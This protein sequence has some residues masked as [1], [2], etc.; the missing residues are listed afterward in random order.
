MPYDF[1]D[2]LDKLPPKVDIEPFHPS[3]LEY[4]VT[5]LSVAAIS[6][7]PHPEATFTFE[8]LLCEARTLGDLDERDV[9]L[10]L[11]GVRFLRRAV[12]RGEERW[13]LV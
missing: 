6:L 4:I 12:A 3:D 9:R 13:L 2:A 7:T 1:D 11:P 10:V 8:E 5:M